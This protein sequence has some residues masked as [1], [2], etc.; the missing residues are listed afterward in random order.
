[1]TNSIIAIR[2]YHL[3]NLDSIFKSFRSVDK[4][5]DLSFEPSIKGIE[6]LFANYF[7]FANQ[8]IG[9]KGITYIN[10]WT[11]IID[12]EMVDISDTEKLIQ[13]SEKLD[14]KILMFLSEK[15]SGHIEFAKIDKSIVR[16]FCYSDSE[17]IINQG[18]PLEEELGLNF[19]EKVFSDDLVT[20]ANKLGVDIEFK[21]CKNIIVK[22][23]ELDEDFQREIAEDK[24][25]MERW[26][27]KNSKPWW[28]FW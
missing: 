16:H 24:N 12:P 3:N 22:Q 17:V 26:S 10:D 20:L 5:V 25:I 21:N 4:K 14:S 2:G 15:I 19:N 8:N 23:L 18:I 9:L 13:I 7:D 1:M 11:L 27:E 6:Y 28:K